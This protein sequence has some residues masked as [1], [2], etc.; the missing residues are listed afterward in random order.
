MPTTRSVDQNGKELVHVLKKWRKML[1]QQHAEEAE[2]IRS[3]FDDWSCPKGKGK[4]ALN[5][6]PLMEAQEEGRFWKCGTRRSKARTSRNFWSFIRL[7]DRCTP[8]A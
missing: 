4:N 6:L 1:R 5:A 8:H 3:A 7:L 2:A